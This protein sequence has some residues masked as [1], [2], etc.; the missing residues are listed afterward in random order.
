[1]VLRHYSREINSL[2]EDSAYECN[3]LTFSQ[4]VMSRQV[5][6]RTVSHI[7][8]TIFYLWFWIF[9]LISL[10]IAFITKYFKDL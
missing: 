10:L 2:G 5:M 8:D 9:F 1:M 4:Q 3:R 6:S 7:I